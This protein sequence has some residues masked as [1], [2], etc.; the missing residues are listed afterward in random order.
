MQTKPNQAV[1]PTPRSLRSAAASGRGS[2]LAFG[3]KFHRGGK[4]TCPAEA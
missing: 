3:L 2:P 4:A 1:E